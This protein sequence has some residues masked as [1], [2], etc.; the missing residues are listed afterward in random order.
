[1]LCAATVQALEATAFVR[2]DGSLA[3]VV[4]NR[5]D[6]ALRFALQGPAGVS[7]TTLPGHAIA[8]YVAPGV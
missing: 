7:D 1:V 2:P 5:S 6:T 4:L 8:T 3:T